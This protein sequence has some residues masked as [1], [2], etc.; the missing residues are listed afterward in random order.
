MKIK[1]QK[2]INF[3]NTIYPTSIYPT[4][5]LSTEIAAEIVKESILEANQS[6]ELLFGRRYNG[7]F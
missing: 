7:K 2:S 3:I 1:G 4:C 5:V 6:R